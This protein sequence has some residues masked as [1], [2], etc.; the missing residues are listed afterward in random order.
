MLLKSRICEALMKAVVELD[1]DVVALIE[2]A[3]RMET[4]PAS[5]TVLDAILQ[6]LRIAKMQNLPMCQDTGMLIVFADV[7]RSCPLS[8]QSIEQ[9]ILEGCAEA[10]RE[11]Y[12]RRSVVED[13]VYERRN[14]LTNLPPVI[15]WNLVDGSDLTIQILLKGFGSENCSSVRM[16]NPTSGPQTVIQA[17]IDIVKA[18]GGKPCPPIFVGVGLGGTMERA[19]YLSK[20]ALLRDVRLS[21]PDERYRALEEDILNSIQA[22]GIGSGGLGG[23]ITALKVAVEQECTHIAGLPLGVSINCWAD[24]KAK[25][26]WKEGEDA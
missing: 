17:V 22:T 6:N 15:W 16:L 14:I 21:N 2:A 26:V 13:P 23:T 11:A 9:A 19:A 5:K 4:L 24:R 18:A 7:G 3:A 10:V 25:V 8:L 12:F 1:D 20:R